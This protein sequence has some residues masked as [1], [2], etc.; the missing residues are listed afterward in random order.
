MLEPEARLLPLP[1]QGGRDLSLSNSLWLFCQ[2]VVG[3]GPAGPSVLLMNGHKRLNCFGL[4]RIDRLVSHV[5]Y[6]T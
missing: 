1:D 6:A 2:A 4:R 3:S 5:S